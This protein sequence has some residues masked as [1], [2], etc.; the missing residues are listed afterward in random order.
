MLRAGMCSVTFRRLSAQEIIR[1]VT[2]AGLK[3]IEWG[4]DIHVPHGDLAVA[5]EI[6]RQTRESGLEITSYGSYYHTGH[7]DELPFEKV[8]DT[9]H[10]LGAP[11][12]RVWAGKLS[13][14]DASPDYRQKVVEDSRRIAELARRSGIT[15]CFEYHPNTLTDTSES[16]AELLQAI[17]HPAMRSYWQPG[18]GQS[19]ARN[20]RDL[21]R[22]LP[23]LVNVHVYWWLPGNVRGALRDGERDWQKYI[24]LVARTGREHWLLLEFVRGDTAEAFLQ[25]AATLNHWLS[26]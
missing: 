2:Q 22:V 9:A 13:S 20:L 23:W 6:A 7:K 18:V 17:D 19:T 24:S 14:R 26:F 4:G 5:K 10:E 21:G 3:G 15:V 25:D 8:L 1:L 12:I 11:V 16:A